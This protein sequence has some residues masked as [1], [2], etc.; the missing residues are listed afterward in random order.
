M[1]DIRRTAED[2]VRAMGPFEDAN[3]EDA[4]EE[5]RFDEGLRM[6][7]VVIEKWEAEHGEGSWESADIQMG[8]DG[9]IEVK[10]NG[11]GKEDERGSTKE[12]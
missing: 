7:F 6:M 10:I 2:I 8:E 11:N 9:R 4:E 12:D 1:E 5:R 3:E